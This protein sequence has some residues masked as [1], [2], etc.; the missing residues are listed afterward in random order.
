MAV[1]IT[2]L[3]SQV[4][5][6]QDALTALSQSSIDTYVHVHVDYPEGGVPNSSGGTY[7]PGATGGG[8]SSSGGGG[9]YVDPGTGSGHSGFA[10]S[11]DTYIF[12][13]NTEEAAALSTAQAK[14]LN[15]R[16]AETR[17]GG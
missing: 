8:G 9:G 6:L 7:S 5:K 10:P 14:Q 11:G 15:R 4:T 12:N 2:N 13:N 1:T 3:V 17:M 16:R